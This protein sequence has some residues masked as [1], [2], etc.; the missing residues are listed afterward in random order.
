MSK[1]FIDTNVLV[2]SFDGS[3]KDKQ[4]RSRQRLLELEEKGRGVIST[5]VIQEFYV[6][7]VRKL[8]MDPI[9]AKQIVAR[10]DNFEVVNVDH[11]L[12]NEAV[13]CSILNQLSF[14]DA[15]VVV[16]AHHAKC[17]KLWTEDLSHGQTIKNIKIE[18]IFN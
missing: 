8:A 6:C 18:N 3:H 16:C 10:F 11:A 2:Y 17:E 13:D 5:Q 1:V 12:I 15:L 9:V 4:K 7:A 14:W